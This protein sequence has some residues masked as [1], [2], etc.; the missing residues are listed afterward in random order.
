[1]IL[2]KNEKIVC[3]YQEC[4]QEAVCPDCQIPLIWKLGRKNDDRFCEAYCCMRHYYMVPEKVRIVSVFKPIHPDEEET[5]ESRYEKL[6]K[7]GRYDK[8]SICDQD[9]IKELSEL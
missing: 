5:E 6:S 3:D 9:F 7:D 4:L 1:M 2:P 8:L